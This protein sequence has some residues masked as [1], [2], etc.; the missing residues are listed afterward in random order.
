MFRKDGRL[1]DGSTSILI[2]NCRDT[3]AA[4][5][6]RSVHC[7]VTSP[8]YWGLRD[9]GVEGQIG[10]EE[11]PELYVAALVEIFAGVRRALRDDGTLWLN[12]G[13]SYSHGGCGARDDVR[14][15]RQS[16]ND[17][18]PKHHKKLSGLKPKDLVGIPWRVAFALQADGW[19]LRMDNIW[20][21][22]NPM[23]ESVTDR[24]TKAHEY[25]FLLSKS[26]HYYYDA[27]AILEPATYG[28]HK[29]RG[30]PDGAIHAPGQPKQAGFSARRVK[31]ADS[32][33]SETR[34][35]RSV[36]RVGTD[37]YPE[38]HFAVMPRKLAEPCILAGSSAQ[39]CCSQCLAPWVRVEER[40]A[41]VVRAG[42]K[43]A[44]AAAGRGGEPVSGTMVS[45][46][47]RRHL[48]WRE[49]CG[50]CA[51]IMPCTVLDPF[52]GAGTTL[53]VAR[54]HGRRSVGIEINPKY[55]ALAWRRTRQ[56]VLP[57]FA[58]QAVET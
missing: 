14:W 7:C 1:D 50:C 28:E 34:N 36:W 41:M 20:D 22:P 39:G 17:H 30:T 15:P 35:R 32:V 5:P 46:P 13:D 27:A 58:E 48:G 3:L 55:A 21:K 47:T 52:C 29:R 37:P 6:E 38:A 26:E 53:L 45:P 51:S 31:G 23:P 49:T 8:P 10:K 24:P 2:G 11:S 33:P 43:R 56:A 54:E 12:L 16:R 25:V 19:Y 4:L 57:M 42:A 40:T 9:Y 44:G 18:M